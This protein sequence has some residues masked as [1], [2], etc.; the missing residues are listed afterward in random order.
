MELSN[1][2][3]IIIAV[4]GAILLKVFLVRYAYG[5]R[6]FYF[7]QPEE[8]VKE[9]VAKAKKNNVDFLIQL[10]DINNMKALVDR[11]LTIVKNIT[12]IEGPLKDDER[13]VLFDR[14]R[15]L[16]L[17]VWCVKEIHADDKNIQLN[18]YKQLAPLFAAVNYSVNIELIYK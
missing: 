5:K 14:V 2:L 17:L 12:T 4:A 11:N 18:K 13:T 7:Q 10:R 15:N 6:Y 8:L 16:C 1:Y 3:V 9:F